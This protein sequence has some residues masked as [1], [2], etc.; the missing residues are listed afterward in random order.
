MGG[1][2]NMAAVIWSGVRVVLE[3]CPQALQLVDGS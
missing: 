2:Q 3:F 1:D